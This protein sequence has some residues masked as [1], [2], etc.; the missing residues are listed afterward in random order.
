[1][2]KVQ[3][4]GEQWI[5]ALFFSPAVFGVF[6]VA[7]TVLPLVQLI[8]RPVQA[9]ILPKMSRAQGEQDISSVSHFNRQG[10]VAVSMVLLPAIG[11]LFVVAE[12]FMT[13][14]FGEDYKGAGLIFRVYLLG[15][16][17]NAV[18]V[19]TL[20]MSF[21]QTRYV[22]NLNIILVALSLVISFAGAS[23]HRARGGCAGKRIW[24]FYRIGGSYMACHWYYRDTAAR[25]PGLAKGWQDC[26][27]CAGGRSNCRLDAYATGWQCCGM[28]QAHPGKLGICRALYGTSDCHGFWLGFRCL[29]WA[30]KVDQ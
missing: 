25:H 11:L 12:P 27:S 28:E 8:R 15:L 29:S 2:F 7:A 5:V 4:L 9:V 22:M 1:M 13:V 23:L 16:L 21:A 18:E 14:L 26:G 30:W 24:R 19:G 10:N 20:L 17:P 3:R 6:T